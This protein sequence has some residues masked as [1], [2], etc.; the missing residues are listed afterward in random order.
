MNRILCIEDEQDFR[1]TM[2][3]FL[4][5]E[6]FEVFEAPNGSEGLQSIVRHAPDL[7]IS[8]INMPKMNGFDMLAALRSSHPEQSDIPFIFLTARTQKR[9]HMRGVSLGADDYISK[10][11]DLDMLLS[12][13]Q[14]RL[15]KRAFLRNWMD[16]T[17]NQYKSLLLQMLS[18]ELRTPL[19]SI[20]G[21]SD[22]LLQ[23]AN[24]IS[25]APAISAASLATQESMD[26]V[27]SVV[28]VAS[29]GGGSSAFRGKRPSPA[30][31]ALLPP[32]EENRRYVQHI[33]R[34][35]YRL[36]SMLDNTFTAMEIY[37]GQSKIAERAIDIERLIWEVT[38]A[39]TLQLGKEQ[40]H[41]ET[42]IEPELPLLQGDELLI[43]R[44][45]RALMDDGITSDSSPARVY[46]DV[47][48]SEHGQLVVQITHGDSPY[49]RTQLDI[50]AV[51]VATG[52]GYA[53]SSGLQ[54]GQGLALQ[55][56][57]MAMQAHGG[58]VQLFP[59]HGKQQAMLLLF[60]AERLAARE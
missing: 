51:T 10:P 47:H 11:V 25:L 37:S 24:E 33:Q 40:F 44:V 34:A 28:S 26:T 56:A 54:Q 35:G 59:E 1:E 20:I 14:S 48:R 41:C 4:R 43:S 7:V 2:A 5:A 16:S 46:V 57:R 8:D 19:N 13:V 42:H 36:L 60:P 22:L 21:F 12:T 55:F 6:G 39:L 3:D 29:A 53:A 30:T 50:P 27:S 52:K 45:L 15:N 58:Q 31:P 38:Y 23:P 9:D 49:I 18:Q 17:L 32:H